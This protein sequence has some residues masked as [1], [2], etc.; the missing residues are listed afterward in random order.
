MRFCKSNPE[1]G[2]LPRPQSRGRGFR[3]GDPVSHDRGCA[4]QDREDNMLADKMRQYAITVLRRL[5]EKSQEYYSGEG[6]RQLIMREIAAL[7]KEET[8]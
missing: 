8:T 5:A 2:F 7:K 1:Q 4:C 3:P 6:V